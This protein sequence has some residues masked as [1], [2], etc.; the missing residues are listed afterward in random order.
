MNFFS[1]SHQLSPSRASRLVIKYFFHSYRV[2]PK[3]DPTSL[4]AELSTIS[5]SSTYAEPELLKV[6]I[7]ALCEFLLGLLLKIPSAQQGV[8]PSS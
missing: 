4:D 1:L 5:T 7:Y 8:V 3:M 2:R 6:L